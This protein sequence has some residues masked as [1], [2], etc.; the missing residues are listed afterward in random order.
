MSSERQTFRLGAVCFSPCYDEPEQAWPALERSV[1]QAAAEGA[2]LICTPEDCFLGLVPDPT[3]EQIAH[4]REHC[5]EVPGGALFE[6]SAALA[7]E[8]GV[9]LVLCLDERAD[10]K[11]YKTAVF[12]GPRGE[13][14]GRYRKVFLSPEPGVRED[15]AFSPGDRLCVFDLPFARVGIMICFDRRLPEVARELARRGAQVIVCPAAALSE[16][17]L[18]RMSFRAEDNG[19]FVMLITPF[20]AAAFA[21][22]G[23]TLAESA[24]RELGDPPATLVCDVNLS[25]C[26][27]AP[28]RRWQY[29]ELLE[30]HKHVFSR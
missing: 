24:R 10:E 2:Q 8:L 9:H 18:A 1:R 23:S 26:H 17:D 5:E 7:R 3:L 21:P 6:R 27:T 29:F 20:G 16:R 12:I 28:C 30:R 15:R 25:L 22:D 11:L 19:V 14:I 4:I 13:V